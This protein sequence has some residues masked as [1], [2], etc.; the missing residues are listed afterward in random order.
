MYNLEDECFA[1][2]VSETEVLNFS[3]LELIPIVKTVR[4]RFVKYQVIEKFLTVLFDDLFYHTGD[5]VNYE[6][7][8]WMSYTDLQK[9][10]TSVVD[11]LEKKL[12]I[13]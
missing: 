2:S 6:Y 13:Y 4:Q 5:K 10:K 9:I 3:E 12:G 7:K 11:S 8:K 1:F